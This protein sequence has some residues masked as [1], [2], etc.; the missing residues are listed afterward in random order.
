MCM[1]RSES[2]AGAAGDEWRAIEWQKHRYGYQ[3]GAATEVEGRGES[4]YTD[5]SVSTVPGC[6]AMTQH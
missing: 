4:A 6:N 2:A 1:I 3:V 5:R